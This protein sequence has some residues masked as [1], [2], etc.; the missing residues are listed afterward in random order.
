MGAYGLIRRVR[1]DPGGY[2]LATGI[3]PLELPAPPQLRIRGF[4]IPPSLR[5]RGHNSVR[6]LHGASNVFVSVV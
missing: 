1:K 4:S 2:S 3:N 5:Y 6:G